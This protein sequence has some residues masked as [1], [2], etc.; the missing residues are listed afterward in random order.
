MRA[1][2]SLPRLAYVSLVLS[3]AAL[4]ACTDDVSS[5]ASPVGGDPVRVSTSVNK[6]DLVPA[7]I[8]VASLGERSVELWPYTGTNFSGTPQDPI[9]LIF[10]GENDPRQIRAALMSLSGNRSAFGFPAAFPFN[11]TWSDAIGN[12]QTAYAADAA[13]LGSAVQLE[14]GPYGPIRFHMRLFRAG[15][16]TFGNVHFELLIPGTTEHEVL[17]WKLAQDL[18]TVDLVRSGL[19]AR[20]P[21]PTAALHPTEF[22]EIRAPIYNG[23]PV[24]LRGAIGGPLSNVTANVPI[25]SSGVAMMFDLARAVD[26]VPGEDVESFVVTWNQVVPKPFC[27]QGPSSYVLVQGP[28]T[29]NQRAGIDASGE[30]KTDFIA[31]GTLQ[32]TPVNPLTSPP[33]PIEATYVA[34]VQELHAGTLT[35]NMSKAS[36][37]Q[38]QTEFPS[39]GPYRGT[40][41][42][43][44]HVGPTQEASKH[45]LDIDC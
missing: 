21:A 18:V 35:N 28:L 17:S 22:H 40:L 39:D 27:S 23:L 33:T 45:R 2:H 5:V 44:L 13:W 3:L 20:A 43:S 31:S 32:L 34:E 36:M 4:A 38:L 8:A 10:F 41:R 1:R 24:E 7:P 9:N 42:A 14:C 30:Y 25:R 37:F 29:L 11:C 12:V 15:S 26:V 19:L 16:A 6:A